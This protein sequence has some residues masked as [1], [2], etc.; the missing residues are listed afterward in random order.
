MAVQ[1]P[2]Q[3]QSRLSVDNFG[4]QIGSTKIRS[5]VDSG[6]A[7]LRRISTRP[8]NAITCSVILD[9]ADVEVFR[10]FYNTDLNGGITVFE[11]LHPFKEAPAN[12]RFIGDPDI[13]PLGGRKFTLN[14]S[15]EEMPSA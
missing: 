12:F 11:Y 8:V 10:Q 7:K 14:M 5:D 15:W 13:K 2:A 3:I 9:F 1:W 4:Y 6:P